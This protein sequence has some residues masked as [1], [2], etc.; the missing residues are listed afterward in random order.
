MRMG[1]LLVP[2][3]FMNEKSNE[4]GNIGDRF[5]KAFPNAYKP[6]WERDLAEEQES[7]GQDRAES[8]RDSDP[9]A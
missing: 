5:S 9:P 1:K 8:M 6:K 7:E 2:P 4:M 3:V